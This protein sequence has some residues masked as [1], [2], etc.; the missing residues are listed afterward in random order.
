MGAAALLFDEDTCATN[1]MLRDAKMAALVAAADEPITPYISRIR[2]LYESGG[3]SSVMVVGGAGDYLNVADTVVKMKDYSISDV[4]TQALAV[5]AS[6]STTV[7]LA[8]PGTPV[9]WPAVASRSRTVQPGALRPDWKSA[10]REKNKISYGEEV[11][12]R[13][14]GAEQ[15]ACV[16]QTNSLLLALHKVAGM[17]EG[18][19]V[20]AAAEQIVREI[21]RKGLC[22]A[23]GGGIDGKLA[24]PRKYE[25]AA[26]LNRLRMEGLIK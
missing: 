13:L 8:A 20:R 9:D 17:G 26:A 10:V 3:V 1:F 16:E 22:E 14:E 12:L 5:V 11:E 7:P 21:D 4:T 23:L 2:S 24:T 19:Q 18:T 15:L 25:I 6:H